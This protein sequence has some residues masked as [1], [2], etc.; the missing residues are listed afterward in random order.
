MN[1]VNNLPAPPERVH[2][3]LPA[4]EPPVSKRNCTAQLPE[5]A[6]AEFDANRNLE[7]SHTFF[8]E[9]AL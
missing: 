8:A 7:V 2:P 4:T 5:L 6:A 9:R 1:G 3:P